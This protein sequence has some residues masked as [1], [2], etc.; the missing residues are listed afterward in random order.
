MAPINRKGTN[1]NAT[2]RR[3]RILL[4]N[5]LFDSVEMKMLEELAKKGAITI[6]RFSDKKKYLKELVRLLYLNL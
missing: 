4:M 5:G 3:K 6:K 2:T 1:D